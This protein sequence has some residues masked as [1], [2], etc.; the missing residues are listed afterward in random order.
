MEEALRDST[1]ALDYKD[2]P[3]LWRYF[4]PQYGGVPKKALAFFFQR[5]ELANLTPDRLLLHELFDGGW[6]SIF[7]DDSAF[8]DLL[9]E[10][11]DNSYVFLWCVLFLCLFIFVMLFLATALNHPIYAVLYL[12]ASFLGVFLL[13]LFLGLE[14]IG[15]LILLVYVG[16]IAVL[17]LFVLMLLDL[18]EIVLI[19]SV[20]LYFFRFIFF[21]SILFLLLVF[22][23]S[24]GL[25]F[26]VP[27]EYDADIFSSDTGAQV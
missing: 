25:G 21:V 24:S 19:K 17:M 6:A 3:P 22:S 10:D 11:I 23:F 2:K 20:D 7:V 9:F 26:V 18:K 12:V 13:F 1:F 27:V 14:Y 4:D 5:A 8:S 15:M 16:A